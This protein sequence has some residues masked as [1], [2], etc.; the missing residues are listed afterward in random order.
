MAI[1]DRVIWVTGASSGIGE[2]LAYELSRYGARLIL[3]AR[4][5]DALNKVR[6]QCVWP[7]HHTVLPMDL[8]D[9]ESVQ[10]AVAYVQDKF[11]GVDTLINNGGISQRSY[12]NETALEVDRR[13]MEVNFFSAVAITKA[14]LPTMI[15]QGG[16]RIV[17]TSS[18]V[19]YVTTPMRSAYSASKHA[20]HGFYDALRAEHKRDNIKVLL[21]CPGFINTNVSAHAVTGDGTAYGKHDKGQLS[22]MSPDECAK[23]IVH[24]MQTGKDEVLIGGKE[25]LVVY[26]QRWLPSLYRYLITRAAP[27]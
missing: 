12:I 9:P 7:D 1:L 24:A 3:S 4:N 25:R 21:V 22:G 8:S 20:L 19:G 27:R 2:A 17:V 16:G 5:E 13:V 6:E 14:L 18:L 11:D 23:R 26:L 10:Q 15:E